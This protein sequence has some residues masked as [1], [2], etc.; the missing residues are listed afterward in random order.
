[1][2]MPTST[3]EANH[4]HIY[5]TKS[6]DSS[7]ARTARAISA[8]TTARLLLPTVLT[9]T[10]RATAGSIHGWF[11]MMWKASWRASAERTLSSINSTLSSSFLRSSKAR[12][13]H[14]ISRASSDSMPMEMSLAT[15]SS[16][17]TR[18]SDSLGRPQTGSARCSARSILTRRT[19]FRAMRT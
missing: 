13:R 2:T 8:R 19:D 1:M 3:S 6:W 16:T 10:A 4:I 9:T 11:R 7:E 17:S 18:W 12:N 5:L 15:I 14:R